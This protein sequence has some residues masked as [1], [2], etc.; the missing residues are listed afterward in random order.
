MEDSKKSII[1]IGMTGVGKTTIGKVLAKEINKA[2]FDIDL[3]IEKITNLKIKDF[4]KMYGESE[5]RRIEKSTLLKFI[6]KSET[7]VI[8]PGAGIMMDDDNKK[9]ILDNCIAIFLDANIRSLT[10]RLKKKPF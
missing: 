5:F 2:F 3:E 7:H 8:S 1:L 9:I 10:T 6:N 4:F